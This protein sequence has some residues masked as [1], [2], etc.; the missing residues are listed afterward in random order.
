M[1]RVPPGPNSDIGGQNH[2]VLITSPQI[3]FDKETHVIP[4]VCPQFALGV[5]H[6][7]QMSLGRVAHLC[8]AP[9]PRRVPHP[10]L[11]LARVRIYSEARAFRSDLSKSSA[12]SSFFSTFSSPL[13]SRSAVQDTLFIASIAAPNSLKG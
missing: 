8:I 6:V 4:A 9:F 1:S 13:S 7:D 12:S 10:S 3:F 2:N 5:G 11:F